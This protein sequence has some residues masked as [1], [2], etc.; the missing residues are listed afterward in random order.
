MLFAAVR[1]LRSDDWA[2]RSWALPRLARNVGMA[3]A[4]RMAMMPTTTMSSM[5]VKPSSPVPSWRRRLA[6]LVFRFSSM[7]PP[8]VRVV[9]PLTTLNGMGLLDMRFCLTFLRSVPAVVAG[10]RRHAVGDLVQVLTRHPEDQTVEAIA[11]L[12]QLGHFGR[13]Q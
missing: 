5:S 2:L 10:G 6:S 7:V 9:L 4:K 13:H 1:A 8:C 12:F 11:L 3:I